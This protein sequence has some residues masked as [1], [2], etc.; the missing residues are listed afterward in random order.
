MGAA[1]TLEDVNA[2]YGASP[3]LQN[4]SLKIEPGERV[5]IMGRSGAGKSTLLN[6]IYR[7]YADRVAL[8]PQASALVANLPVFHNV[9]MGRLDRHST[10]YNLR[11]L[12]WPPAGEV[13][14]IRGVLSAVGLSEKLF[15]KAGELSGGQQQRTS[16]ARAI[17][18]GRPIVAGDEPVSALDR[19]QAGEVLRLLSERHET[20][21]FALHDIRLALENTDR[22]VLIERGRIVLDEPS[23][24]LS[25]ERLLPYFEGELV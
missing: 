4:F 15:A 18:N 21:I 22:I 3:V 17:Y 10:L 2:G 9:F 23:R 5:A 7:T 12:V 6:L 24:R 14:A 16:V 13:D 11:T 20:K 25:Y 19:L 1:I 8:I